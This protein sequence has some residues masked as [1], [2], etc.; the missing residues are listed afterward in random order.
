MSA[1]ED[2]LEGRRAIKLTTI[3]NAVAS[4]RHPVNVIVL[5]PTTGDSG[6]DV[7]DTKYVPDD[8]EKEF[9]PAGKLQVEEEVD[10]EK[11]PRQRY[12]LLLHGQQYWSTQPDISV[13][14]VYNTVSRNRFM[15]LKKCIHFADN[16][17]LTKDDKMIKVTPLYDM[18]N[19]LLAQFGVFHSLFSV[20]E[21]I[22]PYF[23]RHSTK[24]FIRGSLFAS[25][26]RW[27]GLRCQEKFK[28]RI[29]SQR[30][31]I[32]QPNLIRSYNTGMGSVDLL[33]RLSSAY[34]PLIRKK[35]GIGRFCEHPKRNHSG[36][37][38]NPLQS[39][40]KVSYASG[41]ST[42]S[43]PVSLAR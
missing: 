17:M 24:M 18:L 5:L 28:R 34:R 15:E 36:S 6:D 8:P 40:A 25:A 13:P 12:H 23:S 39:H 2:K 41:I 4:S 3:D 1:N 31:D 29:E 14:L 11:A 30:E 10:T 33:D 22:V 7:S 19:K 21:A 27:Q 42:A 26:E 38:A 20:D 9:E 37:V 32:S 43:G 35:N 16:Q